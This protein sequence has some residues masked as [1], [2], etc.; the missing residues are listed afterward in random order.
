LCGFLALWEER[1]IMN[2]HVFVKHLSEPQMTVEYIFQSPKKLTELDIF[3]A[4]IDVL[5][6]S[7]TGDPIITTDREIK[8]DDGFKFK[9]VS[10]RTEDEK[11][12]HPVTNLL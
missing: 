12:E 2:Y 7:Y 3:F 5:R 6:C 11:Q 10:Y 1:E 4:M 9:V 8:I